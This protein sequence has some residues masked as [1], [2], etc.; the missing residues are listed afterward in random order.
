MKNTIVNLLQVPQETVI[1]HCE[2]VDH[3]QPKHE[4][5]VTPNDASKRDFDF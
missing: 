4:L 2:L 3:I 5:N 1:F